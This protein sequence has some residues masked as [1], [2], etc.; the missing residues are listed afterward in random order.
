M[1]RWVSLEAIKGR[2]HEN[3]LY[4]FVCVNK[5]KLLMQKN[6]SFEPTRKVPVVYISNLKSLLMILP[7]TFII[8]KI[9]GVAPHL[10]DRG[11]E[12]NDNSFL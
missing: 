6:T 1:P 10:C 12:G 3:T 2:E 8:E 4:Y 7:N 9:V 5:V 11:Y